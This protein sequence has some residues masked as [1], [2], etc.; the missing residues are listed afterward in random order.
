MV[1]VEDHPR[2][3]RIWLAH[4]DLGCGEGPVQIVFGGRPVVTAESLVAVAPPGATVATVRTVRR[5]RRR[6]YRGE[7][8]YGMLCSLDELGWAVGAPD[9]VAVLKN[10]R[11]GE[12]LDGVSPVRRS[13]IVKGPRHRSS[14]CWCS[15]GPCWARSRATR[16]RAFFRDESGSP[17]WPPYGEGLNPAL[18]DR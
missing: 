6:S 8:S 15:S 9:E 12:S 3:D 2:A 14:G 13:E 17:G 11:A 18:R 5:M 4:V 1:K 10:V 7:S 16:L